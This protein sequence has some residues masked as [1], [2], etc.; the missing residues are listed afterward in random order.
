MSTY[1]TR[2]QLLGVSKTSLTSDVDL[3]DIDS[4]DRKM[5]SL[6]NTASVQDHGNTLTFPSRYDDSLSINPN[7]L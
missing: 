7:M 2:S 5:E 4:P 6:A 3:S 1:L